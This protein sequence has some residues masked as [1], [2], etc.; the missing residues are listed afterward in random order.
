MKK[1]ILLLSL[2]FLLVGFAV[3]PQI[4]P[5][6]KRAV[7]AKASTLAGGSYQSNPLTTDLKQ[8]TFETV[9]RIVKEKHY[10]PKLNGVDWD[11]V[12]MRY[13]PLIAAT[14]TEGEFY[15][16]LSQM[17]SELNQ[18]HFAIIPPSAFVDTDND[19]SVDGNR[20]DGRGE[21]GLSLAWIEEQMIV[22]RVEPDS[23]AA[24]AGLRPGF[25]ITQIDSKGFDDLRR[26]IAQRKERPVMER[27][28]M[29]RAAL[30]RLSGRIGTQVRIKCLDE[31]NAPRE[32]ELE[33]RSPKGQLVKFG[34]LPPVYANLEKKR[35]PSGIG[36]IR[37]N[38]F[39]MPLLAQIQE[40]V[41]SFSN[42]PGI[43]ID[44]RGNP[45]GLG[46]MASAVA[47][48][49]HREQ[50]QLGTMH[51]RRGES[52]FVVFPR[53]D[54]YTGPLAIITDEGSAST[55]EVLAG[56]LQESGR[57]IIV[58]N[59]T[60]GAVLPSV[61]EE[62]PTGARLQYAIAD[63]KTPKGVL[64]EGWGVKPDIE[65]PLS[66]SAFLEGRDPAFESAESAILKK[67]KARRRT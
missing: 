2:L 58:G 17:L 65:V 21:T 29:A 19:Q 13:S 15:A 49:F 10:D 33:R 24:R 50:S 66:R 53:Q 6:R 27:F 23:S 37:F 42:A 16:L 41:K 62:L 18:S 40:A 56:G 61:I 12:R 35:L 54:A 3:S 47:A 46:A 36:Y 51:M 43:I 14:K 55:S 48:L 32:V 59:T 38:I 64:L 8:R 7:H 28:L 30:A 22:T 11:S 60:L 20:S 67:Q 4:A 44:L 25:V 1:T 57:A 63:F 34:N 39:M 45:G 31:N 5:D 9:W 26:R 52:H